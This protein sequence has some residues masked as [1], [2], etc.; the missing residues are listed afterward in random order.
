[1]IVVTSIDNV[2][3]NI[4]TTPEIFQ[5]LYDHFCFQPVGYAHMPRY[6]D[7]EWDGYIRLIKFDGRFYRGLVSSLKR[8]AETKKF[9]IQ[10]DVPEVNS[11]EFTIE[12]TK[13]FFAA[14]TDAEKFP[15]RDHQIYSFVECINKERRVI[16]SAT[17]SGKSLSIYG[18]ARYFSPVHK[19]LIIVPTVM[20]VKQMAK[21]FSDYAGKTFPIQQIHAGKSKEITE[22]I[23]VTTWQSIIGLVKT[24]R[25]WFDQFTCVICDEVH[26][27]KG[28]SIST[29]LETLTEA[30]V[31]LGFTGSLTDE[32]VNHL[33]VEGLLGD[34]TV[35]SK[36]SDLIKKGE[37]S[38]IKINVI[39]FK[40][41]KMEKMIAGRLGYQEQID[42]INRHE[43]RWRLL[44]KII[45]AKKK[46]TLVLFSRKDKFGVP[47]YQELKRQEPNRP[48]Y[49]I[50]GDTKINERETIRTSVEKEK[51]AIIL[52][53]YTI[54]SEGV[55]IKNLY[56]LVGASATASE[57]RIIQAIGRL[58]RLGTDGNEV[59]FDDVVDDLIDDEDR[60]Y[61]MQHALSRM[62][63]Y[64][65]HRYPY[66]VLEVKL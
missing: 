63:I 59:Q 20:L 1:M 17:G 4:D 46:N 64:D 15:L 36:A 12:D 30:T 23:T 58:L 35:A 62:D 31:R 37:L 66:R 50:T 10:I 9:P 47:L 56:H 52:A 61:F 55:N 65:K 22:R 6:V 60:N 27:A 14:I 41:K 3:V 28:K 48:I 26:K 34:S 49:L 13:K 42:F 39:V 21:D 8:F 43:E 51:N 18:I 29:I 57:Q 54:F 33:V 19:V 7:G 40:Y 45:L 38:K 11:P 5:E 16:E 25:K 44:K 32:K 53:T 24:D 2:F